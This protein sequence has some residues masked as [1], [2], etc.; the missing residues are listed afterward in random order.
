MQFQKT[1][2][3]ISRRVDVGA[4]A[5]RPLFT[6]SSSLTCFPVLAQIESAFSVDCCGRARY[7]ALTRYRYLLYNIVCVLF[8][9]H[10]LQASRA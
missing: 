9:L 7:G 6:S 2:H 5:T 4:F 8:V 10:G 3:D 1:S